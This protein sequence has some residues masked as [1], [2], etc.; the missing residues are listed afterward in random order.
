VQGEDFQPQSFQRLAF[1]RLHL[2]VIAKSD[3]GISTTI[4]E[5]LSFFA[6]HVQNRSP[7]TVAQS[8]LTALLF[9]FECGPERYVSFRPH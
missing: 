2:C 8:F 9:R 7:G 5:F 4:F 1:V 3:T 6:E